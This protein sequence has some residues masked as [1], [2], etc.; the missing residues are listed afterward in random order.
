[1]LV[2]KKSIL[3]IGPES[4]SLTLSFIWYIFITS[5]MKVKTNITLNKVMH[6]LKITAFN[7][8]PIS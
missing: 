2:L 6:M 5:N 8:S 7:S 1:M 4:T 3:I